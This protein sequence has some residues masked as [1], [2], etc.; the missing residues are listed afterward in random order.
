MSGVHQSSHKIKHFL[1]LR[2]RFELSTPNHL[3]NEA[4][5]LAVVVYCRCF[6][7][8]FTR[9]CFYSKSAIFSTQI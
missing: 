2:E 7:S 8:V 4:D 5:R 3:A 9:L 6:E 1:Q